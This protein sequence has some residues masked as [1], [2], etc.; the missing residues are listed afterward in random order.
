M[1][2][3]FVFLEVANLIIHVNVQILA[4]VYECMLHLLFYLLFVVFFVFTRYSHQ[5]NPTVPLA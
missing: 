5:S 1:K 2:R 4:Q 3:K